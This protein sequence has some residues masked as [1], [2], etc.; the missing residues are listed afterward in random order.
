MESICS[1]IALPTNVCTVNK[2]TYILW[3]FFFI[4]VSLFSALF[5][6]FSAWSVCCTW[7]YFFFPLCC[8]FLCVSLSGL[9]L[10]WYGQD[11][12]GVSVAT[13]SVP[14]T[15]FVPCTSAAFSPIRTPRYIFCQCLICSSYHFMTNHVVYIYNQKFNRYKDKLSSY[16]VC[17]N[18]LNTR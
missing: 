2:G 15:W 1:Y 4:Y 3:W 10:T 7:Q 18:V 12:V 6:F 5:S 11:F 13:Q 8:I 9:F 16:F 17:K 14:P